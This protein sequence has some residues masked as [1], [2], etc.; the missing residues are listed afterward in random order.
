MPDKILESVHPDYIVGIT[1]WQKYGL[2]YDGG[3]PFIEKYLTQFSLRETPQ[4]FA[5]RKLL[6]YCPRHAGAAIDEIKNSIFQRLVDV[7]RTGGNTEMMKIWDGDSQSPGV[8]RNGSSINSFFGNDVLIELLVKAKVGIYVDMPAGLENS[9]LQEAKDKMPYMYVYNAE[10]ILNWTHNSNNE[11]TALLLRSRVLRLNEFDMPEGYEWEFRLYKLTDD[12]V[13]IQIMDGEGEPQ[14]KLVTLELKQIPFVMIEINHS[15]I[16]DTC[17]IQIALLN[18]ESSDIAYAMWSNFPFYT[19]QY[20]PKDETFNERK[21][22]EDDVDDTGSDQVSIITET[23]KNESSKEVDVGTTQGRQYPMN[24]ERPGYIHP[25]PEPLRVSM[26]KQQKMEE[27]IRLLTNLRLMNIRPKMMSA[28]S[29]EVDNQGLEAGL[30]FIGQIL[31]TVEGQLAKIWVDYLSL[32][33]AD[34]PVISYPDSWQLLPPEE[35]RSRTDHLL[36]MRKRVP[37]RK[38]QEIITLQIADINVKD[39]ATRQE[40]SEIQKEILAARVF[41]DDAE[42]VQKDMEI[43]ALDHDLG[44]QIRGYPEGTGAKAQKEFVQ[45]AQIIAN[46]QKETA[47]GNDDEDPDPNASKK[48]EKEHKDG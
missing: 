1:P 32:T 46:M 44:S 13:T 20:D 36:E 17:D 27:K 9:S 16:Q 29:K 37:S 25:S 18:L 28:A 7:T 45:R 23:D 39:V 10:D 38:F 22:D 19:E 48:G 26:E 14:G 43:G 41:H 15:L 2:S 33:E 11:L 30:S 40:W 47:R 3:A 5:D 8:D 4:N 31:E 21:W 34:I 42:S 6:T 24:L 12:G 35:R